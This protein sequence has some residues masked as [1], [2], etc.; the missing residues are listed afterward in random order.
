MLLELVREHVTRAEQVAKQGSSGKKW[1]P[2]PP[3]RSGLGAAAARAV[4]DSADDEGN[5]PICFEYMD[6]QGMWRTHAVSTVT[7][8]RRLD[9]NVINNL[10][11]ISYWCIIE[12]SVEPLNICFYNK[13]SESKHKEFR[14]LKVV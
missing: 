1:D 14:Q 7:K 3:M 5:C 2:L 13:T 4:P 12:F 6:P 9:P 11:P 8:R 10:F